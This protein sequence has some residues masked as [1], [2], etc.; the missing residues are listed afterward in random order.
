M[1]LK[2]L[3]PLRL[4]LFRVS[5]VPTRYFRDTI[6]SLF[7]SRSGL[8]GCNLFASSSAI[9]STFMHVNSNAS[10]DQTAEAHFISASIWRWISL[11]LRFSLTALQCALPCLCAAFSNRTMNVVERVSHNSIQLR[12]R[13]GPHMLGKS[14]CA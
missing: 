9:Y 11:F 1:R 10:A 4:I 8:P 3:G 7:P 12:Q 6:S 14:S 2:C 13:A 5:T